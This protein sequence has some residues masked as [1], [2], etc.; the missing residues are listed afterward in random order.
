MH[1]LIPLPVVIEIKIVS[2]F[3]HEKHSSTFPPF[4]EVPA[5]SNPLFFKGGRWG[6]T[7]ENPLTPAEE[8]KR[9][10]HLKT[11]TK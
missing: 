8:K 1:H 9:N 7:K 11:S 3:G 4:P 10:S 6:I 5:S 2:F